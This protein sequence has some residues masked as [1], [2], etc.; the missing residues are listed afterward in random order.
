[1]LPRR[2]LFSLTI[3]LF[4]LLTLW[5]ALPRPAVAAEDDYL[6]GTQLV[7]I[8]PTQL[9]VKNA[10]WV[11]M[12][13]KPYSYSQGTIIDAINAARAVR[14]V[15]TEVDVATYPISIGSEMQ[16]SGKW[17]Y[18]IDFHW[19]TP[20]DVEV[21]LKGFPLT[22][23]LAGL[24]HV[25]RPLKTALFPSNPTADGLSASIDL[26]GAK[27]TLTGDDSFNAFKARITDLLTK[28]FGDRAKFDLSLDDIYMVSGTNQNG[29]A[30]TLTVYLDGAESQALKEDEAP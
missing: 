24:D 4:S 3:G 7:L 30:F 11:D 14:G 1:M 8:S 20:A 27:L 16:R 15:K 10:Y 2:S 22:G 25:L 23:K 5:S 13:P 29:V 17:E 26:L 6:F 28:R 9:D 21:V 12:L 18:N 19:M